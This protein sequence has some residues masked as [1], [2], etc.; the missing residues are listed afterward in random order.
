MTAALA[1]PAEL[2]VRPRQLRALVG[3]LGPHRR[4][5]ALAIAK[6]IPHQLVILGTA[7]TAAWLVGRAVT[8]GSAELW[9]GLVLL[10]VLVL[11]LA[12]A[13]EAESYLTH[14]AASRAGCTRRSSGSL[15]VTARAPLR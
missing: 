9:P 7:G 10:D 11:P 5:L 14:V 8:G 3:L 12:V 4:L 15:R 2:T 6:G 1:E 13:P